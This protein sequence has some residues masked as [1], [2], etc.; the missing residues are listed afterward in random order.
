MIYCSTVHDRRVLQEYNNKKKKTKKTHHTT[1]EQNP[2]NLRKQRSN[3]ILRRIGR[4]K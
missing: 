2:N 3:R 4:L 1:Q